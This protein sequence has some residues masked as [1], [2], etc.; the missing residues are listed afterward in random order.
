MQ[1]S[2]GLFSR[3]RTRVSGI[4]FGFRPRRCATRDAFHLGRRCYPAPCWGPPPCYLYRRPNIGLVC[5]RRLMGR[6]LFLDGTEDA[7]CAAGVISRW[8]FCGV[9]LLLC[10]ARLFPP[11]RGWLLDER[12][13]L[14]SILLG[15]RLRP[16]VSASMSVLGAHACPHEKIFVHAARR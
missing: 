6:G 2:L 13:G 11:P 1:G 7:P 5:C 15:V 10:A 3:R 8:T 12:G 4:A 9:R 14:N 16:P